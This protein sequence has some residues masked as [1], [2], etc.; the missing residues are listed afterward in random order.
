[1]AGVIDEYLA[2][3]RRDLAFDPGLADRLVAEVEDHLREAVEADPRG[4]TPDAERRAVERF[5]LAREIAAQCARDAID[6]QAR[7]TW[8]TLAIAVVV[9]FV[10]MRLRVT[11]LDDGSPLSLAPLV[12]R[13]AFIAAL[14]GG[15]VAW[16][17]RRQ[18]AGALLGC[19]LGLAA[20]IVAGVLRADLFGSGAPPWVVLPAVAEIAMLV[21]LLAHLAGWLR[22]LKQ[23]AALR[24]AGT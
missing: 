9:T 14:V 16:F 10:A 8:A 6:R 11:W 4:A 22:R 19:A 15:L 12:D 20:S 13:Y 5:G 23:T 24:R 18:S 1:M 21:V 17:A 3:L 2:G 7:R